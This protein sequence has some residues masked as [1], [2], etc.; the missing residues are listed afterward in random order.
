ML[1]KKIIVKPIRSVWQNPV[2]FLAFGFGSGT[3]PWM[4][5]TFGA[6]A[7]IPL[8][9]FI[10]N[11]PLIYYGVITLILIIIGIGLCEIT[12]RALGVHDYAGIVW[13]EIVGYLVT[14]FAVPLEWTW[15]IAGFVLFRIFD[16]WKPW[17]ISWLNRHVKGGL[18]IIVDDV[19][20][21]VFACIVLQLAGYFLIK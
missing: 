20:A 18:G 15:I 2:H 3:L 9:L 13:D 6:V 10:A 12:E 4:P 11:L 5:G 17:P 1:D 21:G 16:I 8:Y 19:L 14:M 7:A